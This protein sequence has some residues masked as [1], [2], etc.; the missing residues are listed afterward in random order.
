MKSYFEYNRKEYEKK[1]KKIDSMDSSK[2]LD[3]FYRYDRLRDS[4]GRLFILTLTTY[5]FLGGLG[6]LFFGILLFSIGTPN[7]MLIYKDFINASL[8]IFTVGIWCLYIAFIEIII[9]RIQ[10]RKQ[11]NE[12]DGKYNI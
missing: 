7:S 2:R 5:L 4:Y 9:C 8:K 1:Q 6:L 3:Y 10:L 12:L 11:L